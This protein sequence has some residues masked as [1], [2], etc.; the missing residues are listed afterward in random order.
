MPL[1]QHVAHQVHLIVARRMCAR[2]SAALP[3]TPL[4]P[5]LVSVLG[6]VDVP[7]RRSGA[8]GVIDPVVAMALGRRVGRAESI[9][10]TE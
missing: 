9:D 8:V 6:S 2:L 4:V 3:A 5:A 7:E 10:A 1:G